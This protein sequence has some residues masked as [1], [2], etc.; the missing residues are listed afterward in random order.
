MTKPLPLLLKERYKEHEE[1]NQLGKTK[2]LI[3]SFQIPYLEKNSLLMS[4]FYL[5]QDMCLDIPYIFSTNKHRNTKQFFL[6]VHITRYILA[7]WRIRAT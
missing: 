3:S 7:I 6:L 4:L 5:K 2:F 1:K